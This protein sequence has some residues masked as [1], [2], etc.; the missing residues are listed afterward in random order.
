MALSSCSVKVNGNDIQVNSDWKFK[1]T[2]SE[3]L[4]IEPEKATKLD[5]NINVGK[6]SV[7]YEKSGNSVT[8]KA[9]AAPEIDAEFEFDGKKIPF[10]GEKEFTVEIGG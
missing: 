8:V 4:N 2:K 3:K 10:S 1:Q 7:E 5:V 9:Y 6:I